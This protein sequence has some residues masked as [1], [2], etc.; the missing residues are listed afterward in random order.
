MRLFSRETLASIP[1]AF[2]ELSASALERV[3]P[4]FMVRT[5]VAEVPLYELVALFVG[6]PILY[7]L[8]GVLNRILSLDAGVLRLSR[9]AALPNPRILPPP[10]RLLLLA[11][12]I[13]WLVSKIPLPLLA[14]EFW[15]ATALVITVVACMWLL[16]DLIS[17][18]ESYLVGRSSSGLSGSRREPSG[19]SLISLS[20]AG[21]RRSMTVVSSIA[22]A[23]AS[24]RRREVFR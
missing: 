19:L 16:M 13:R 3:L 21:R 8:T 7:L 1:D 12:A 20:R 5:R 2:Q 22:R 17:W 6:M 23:S 24:A 4:N 14:R 9:N 11:L 18:G 10:I 15:P